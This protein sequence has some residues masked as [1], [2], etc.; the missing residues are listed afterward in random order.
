MNSE[1]RQS[2]AA[3]VSQPEACINLAKAAL[4]IAKESDPEVDVEAYLNALDVMASEVAERLPTERYP[5]RIIR[6]IN[7]YLFEDLGYRGNEKDYY[8]PRNS[9]LNQVIERRTGIPITLSLVY[10]EIAQ[11]LDFPMMGVGMPGHF[12]I[13]PTLDEME[14]F[15]DPFNQGAVLFSEDCQERLSQVYGSPVEMRPEYLQTV[16]VYQFLMRMLTNLKIIYLNQGDLEQTLT[17]V[18]RILLLFPDAVRERRDRGLIYYEQ[19]RWDEAIADLS[20][21]LQQEPIANDRPMIQRLLD[22]MGGDRPGSN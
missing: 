10:L 1:T 17:A 5:L 2:F 19:K 16:S 12:L 6:T 18:E 13:R 3:E 21:Y 20:Y 8:D 22:I 11:R 4:Y 9:F 14:V 7:H 15:V